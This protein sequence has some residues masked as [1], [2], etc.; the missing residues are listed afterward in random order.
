MTIPITGAT[1][2]LYIIGDPIRQ[3]RAPF[4][5]NGLFR[6]NGI[7]AVCVP[8]HIA[9]V[10]LADFLRGVRPLKNMV[11]VIVT[12]PHKPAAMAAVTAPTERAERAGVVNVMR[13]TVQ[14][15]AG[16]IVDGVGFVQGLLARGQSVAGR[17]ALVVGSG[18][19]GSAIAFAL[20]RSG[21]REVAVTDIMPD[22]AQDLARRIAASG[23]PAR[24]ST[25]DASGFDLVVNAS[26]LGMMPDDPLP[27]VLDR[28]APS[29]VVADAVA[30]PAMTRLLM[31]AGDR[32][33]F[34]QPGS[35]M[36][37]HQIAASAEFFG[38]AEGDWSA[39][40]IAQL[41]PDA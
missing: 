27:V 17:R 35:Y 32:G 33:C 7:D 28:V 26:P 19:V 18:G 4:I 12:V 36:M 31:A 10:D 21:A 30:Y 6:H 3:V 34:V 15:W 40:A 37:D 22:R 11:G 5:W 14:G 1:R 41:T 2:V 8:M 13:S 39:D 24:A 23:T 25:A 20:A 16:D 38:F 9:G 29:T